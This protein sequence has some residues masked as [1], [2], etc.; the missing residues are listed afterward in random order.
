MG[1]LGCT[2]PGPEAQSGKEYVECLRPLLQENGL[3]A[4]TLLDLAADRY[5][6]KT[7]D[8]LLESRWRE[9]IVPLADH[10]HTQAGLVTPPTSWTDRHGGLVKIWGQ[11]ADAYSGMSLSI[12]L[13]D[14]ERW[15]QSMSKA[16]DA[17]VDEERWFRDVNRELAQWDLSL[18]QFP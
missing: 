8:D 14:P 11:R 17:K 18:D 9:D 4:N 15:K 10:L 16:D 1:W 13:G 6:D 12:R 7:T 2:P 5:H 3:L